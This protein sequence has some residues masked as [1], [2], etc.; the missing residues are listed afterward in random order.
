MV[1]SHIK[2]YR[3]Q[4]GVVSMQVKCALSLTFNSQSTRTLP[5]NQEFMPKIMFEL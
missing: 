5:N 3:E 2:K 1:S 4:Y